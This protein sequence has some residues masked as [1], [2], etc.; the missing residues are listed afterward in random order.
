MVILVI[1]FECMLLAEHDNEAGPG[2]KA[3]NEDKYYIMISLAFYM[4]EGIGSVLP[5]M[6]ASDAK[7]NFNYLLGS[8]L[9][10]L[11]FVHIIFSELAYY[12]YGN[13][14]NEPILIQKL[15]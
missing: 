5:V 7:E 3:F 6:E 4:F 14:L 13:D 2:W 1:I 10:T 15:P 12:T 9:A 11:C 8:A